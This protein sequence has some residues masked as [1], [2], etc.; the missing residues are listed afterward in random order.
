MQYYSEKQ[1]REV[2]LTVESAT[3]QAT[4]QALE[5]KI[6]KTCNKQ[7]DSETGRG[8]YSF[9][10]LIKLRSKTASKSLAQIVSAPSTESEL[11]GQQSNN[12]FNKPSTPY[13]VFSDLISSC[14]LMLPLPLHLIFGFMLTWYCQFMQPI[15]EN[16][17]NPV[18]FGRVM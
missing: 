2:H 16:Y 9:V 5:P 1:D 17:G 8:L 10:P 6:R 3:N 12:W 13:R 11:L 4:D 14:D 15:M 18:S 7:K